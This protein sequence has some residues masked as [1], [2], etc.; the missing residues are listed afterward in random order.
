MRGGPIYSRAAARR[1]GLLWV[2]GGLVLALVGILI[3][4]FSYAAATSGATGGF[5]FI[6]IWPVLLGVIW[7]VRG[8]SLLA[9]SSR[10]P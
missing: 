4:V 10:L 9:R 3:S 6:A 5:T 1:R 2:G 7:V 8:L